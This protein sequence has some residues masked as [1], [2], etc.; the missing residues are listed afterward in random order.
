[1][2][3]VKKIKAWVLSVPPEKNSVWDIIVWWEA[4]RI[5]YNAIVGIYGFLS[6]I[7][8]FVFIYLSKELKPGEDAIE[9]MALFAA[10]IMIN[11][12]Y[13]SGWV[14]EVFARLVLGKSFKRI[15]NWLFMA[16]TAFSLVVASIPSVV[17]VIIWIYRM[18][19]AKPAA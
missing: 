6:L 11:M 16:G 17:W 4:R 12:C 18:I 8:Y 9:P 13:T 2:T 15:G 1:M 10:L 14:F 5:P 3:N 7:L 19:H